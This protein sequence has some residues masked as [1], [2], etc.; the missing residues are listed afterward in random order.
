MGAHS[1]ISRTSAIRRTFDA[2]FLNEIANDPQVFPWMES[3]IVVDMTA[4]ALNPAN[5][6]LECDAGG[7][8]LIQHEPGRYEVHSIFR[9]GTGGAPIRAMRAAMDWMFTRTTCETITSKIPDDNQRARGFAIAGGLRTIFRGKDAAYVEIGVMDWAMRSKAL[10]ASGRR[11]HAALEAAKIAA[12]SSLPIHD[13]D[14]A[15]EQAVGAA[16]LMI[17][18][19][20][21]FKGVAFYNRWARMAGYA[22]ISLISTSPVTVDVVD[23]VVSLGDDGLEILLCR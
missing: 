16:L 23:A 8:L 13:D 6:L 19:G 1:V 18:R 5:Y 7:F 20:Q 4:L 2:S 3:A 12:G 21:P 14:A 22:Q 17:E 15:H 10:I 9:P 11:F